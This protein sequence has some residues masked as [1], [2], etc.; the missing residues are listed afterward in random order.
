MTDK[1]YDDQGNEIYFH[2]I[3]HICP[4]EYATEVKT[5]TQDYC[6]NVENTEDTFDNMMSTKVSASG[7]EPCEYRLCVASLLCPQIQMRFDFL[8][9][10]PYEWICH[11][12][13]TLEDDYLSH[14]F[15]IIECTL[16]EFLENSGLK[17]ID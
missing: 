17:V 12:L 14:G 15:A 8:E 16:E 13:L 4:E 11:E 7:E 9:E 5:F 2:D 3:I 10:Q 1:I 6:N